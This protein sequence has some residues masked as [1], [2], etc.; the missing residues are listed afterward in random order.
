[1]GRGRPIFHLWKAE[2]RRN[3]RRLDR[4]CILSVYNIQL[5]RR[6]T[7]DPKLPFRIYHGRRRIESEAERRLR[8]PLI[9]E[10]GRYVG[11]DQ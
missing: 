5:S 2:V 4:T 8:Y 1:M 11:G 7:I 3:I 6:S 9:L 10:I